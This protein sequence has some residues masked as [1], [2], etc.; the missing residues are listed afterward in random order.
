MHHITTEISQMP[1]PIDIEVGRKLRQIRIAKGFTQTEIANNLALSFQ[2]IQKYERGSNRV[3]ASRLWKISQVLNVDVGFFFDG[4][5]NVHEGAVVELVAV[6]D[7]VGRDGLERKRGKR[8]GILLRPQ[9]ALHGAQ[10]D[11]VGELLNDFRLRFV[12]L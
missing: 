8:D 1:H 3:G 9:S 7:V 4:L 2:Q 11:A 10:E 6:D 12:V 5:A